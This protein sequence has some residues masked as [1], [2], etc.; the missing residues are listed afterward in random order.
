MSDSKTE[1]NAYRPDL[2]GLRAIS[3]LAVVF[4]HLDLDWMPGGFV[5]VDVFFVISGFLITQIVVRDVEANSFSY[6]IF[7]IRRA[8]RLLPA[9]FVTVLIVLTAGYLFFLLQTI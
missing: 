4:Y 8:Y 3:I 2:D 6:S 5:G 9:L 1:Q 7:Y